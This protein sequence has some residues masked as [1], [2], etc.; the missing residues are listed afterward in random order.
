MAWYITI[1][2]SFFSSS[3]IIFLFLENNHADRSSSKHSKLLDSLNSYVHMYRRG[4]ETLSFRSS[5]FRNYDPL[6]TTRV[7]TQFNYTA[8]FERIML[9]WLIPEVDM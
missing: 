3:F 9:S 8:N 7:H 6:T 4:Y 1:L 2:F 5:K